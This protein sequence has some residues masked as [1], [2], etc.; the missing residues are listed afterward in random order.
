[1]ASLIVFI[2]IP[3]TGG[4]SIRV[5]AEHYFGPKRM[6]YDYGPEAR[7]TSKLVKKWIY[8]NKDFD[9][10]SHA[11][12]EGKYRFLSGHF[13]IDKYYGVLQSAAFV[14]WLREPFSRLW[15]AYLHYEKHLGF[16]G[17]FEDFYSEN[18]FSNQQSRLLNN[19]LD[20][21]DFVGITKHFRV[22]LLQLN[23]QFGIDLVQYKAN[24]TKSKI[25]YLP[26]D[27]DL[28]VI[29]EKNFR[30]KALYELATHRLLKNGYTR[31]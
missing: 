14:S 25:N 10:F 8:K 6:L 2:H 15:S 16:K 7:L 13:P 24:K 18:R 1:M 12:S 17:S 26:Q 11:V 9:G 27:E 31:S 3:K 23:K 5:A 28:S 19:D 22:S 20:K 4:T 29:R 30:D 21:L